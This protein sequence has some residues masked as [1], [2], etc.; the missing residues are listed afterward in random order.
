M[1]KISLIPKNNIVPLFGATL[2]EIIND[3][4]Q[5]YTL[6]YTLSPG[7]ETNAEINRYSAIP[8]NN[9]IEILIENFSYDCNRTLTI[10]I[11]TA[12]GMYATT[13]L[14][15]R[16]TFIY[17]LSNERTI[18][19]QQ[20]LRNLPKQYFSPNIPWNA[21]TL[22]KWSANPT[23]TMDEY[24]AQP[25]TKIMAVPEVDTAY[26]I[27]VTNHCA[28]SKSIQTF[29]T[30]QVFQMDAMVDRTLIKKHHTAAYFLPL[31]NHYMPNVFCNDTL[32]ETTIPDTVA[33]GTKFNLHDSFFETAYSDLT[34]NEND[35]QGVACLPTVLRNFI[36]HGTYGADYCDIQRMTNKGFVFELD[37]TILSS[38]QNKTLYTTILNF[39]LLSGYIASSYAIQP[40]QFLHTFVIPK[41]AFATLNPDVLFSS[42]HKC[43]FARTFVRG[44]HSLLE[45]W[46]NLYRD[47][48]ELVPWAGY[49]SYGHSSWG[50]EI[51]S[52][53]DLFAIMYTGTFETYLSYLLHDNWAFPLK[54][55]LNMFA[56]EFGYHS[57]SLQ[58]G[59]YAFWNPSINTVLYQQ[60]HDIFTLDYYSF[61]RPER[62]HIQLNWLTE[63]VKNLV[64]NE[65][66]TYYLC[67]IPESNKLLVR[68]EK[69]LTT[70]DHTLRLTNF[71]LEFIHDRT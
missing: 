3:T 5:S 2:V 12:N 34:L 63:W 45:N 15:L 29:T 40:N 55:G 16:S 65:N 31:P 52:F 19:L 64:Y 35:S 23:I 37:K 58:D 18:T 36:M 11:T 28:I 68:R 51:I 59:A 56:E 48:H 43:I 32:L 20:M 13:T 7:V 22:Y 46:F 30:A 53:E 27:T 1:H 71:T 60:M 62:K 47:D 41:S 4:V 50:D 14:Y 33:F 54:P 9:P 26:E 25:Y 44:A 57:E 17:D 49:Q 21:N 39:D 67:I 61:Q 38:L 42:L 69:P 6:T 70:E 8:V 66:D 10:V 24:T